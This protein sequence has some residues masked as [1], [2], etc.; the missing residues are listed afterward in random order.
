MSLDSKLLILV[1]DGVTSSEKAECLIDMGYYTLI[2]EIKTIISE[3]SQS[4][5]ARDK[6]NLKIRIFSREFRPIILIL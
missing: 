3:T 5:F 2:H 1:A 4:I 6:V